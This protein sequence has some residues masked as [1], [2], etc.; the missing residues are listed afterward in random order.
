M[1]KIL[2]SYIILASLSANAYYPNNNQ[3]Q[4]QQQQEQQEQG[5]RDQRIENLK[6]LIENTKENIRNGSLGTSNYA[7][8]RVGAL[9]CLVRYEKKGFNYK[10]YAGDIELTNNTSDYMTPS[11][12]C[13]SITSY[14]NFS[15]KYDLPPYKILQ[16]NDVLIQKSELSIGERVKRIKSILLRNSQRRINDELENIIN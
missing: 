9:G 15:E 14:S 4:Q 1:K 6:I 3:Q 13:S 11:S 7:Q 8:H 10:T 12:I 16:M 5:A 2:L